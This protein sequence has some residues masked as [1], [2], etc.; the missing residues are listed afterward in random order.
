MKLKGLY[1][2]WVIVFVS[3]L[4]QALNSTAELTPG[5]FLKALTTHFECGRGDISV[6]FS[7]Y[8]LFMAPLSILSGKLSDK[9]GPRIVVTFNALLVG[10]GYVLMSRINFLWQMYLVWVVTGIG[11]SGYWVP[12]VSTVARWFTKRRGVAMGVTLTG[13]AVGGIIMPLFAQWLISSYG[14][15]QAY[16]TLG[17]VT[18]IILLPSVQLM[19]RS[20]QI[21]LK[22]LGEV[23]KDPQSIENFTFIELIK[24]KQFWLLGITL[25]LF[26]FCCL[27]GYVHTAPYAI[28]TGISAM[29]AATLLTIIAGGSLVGRLLIGSISDMIGG[30]LTLVCA[31]ILFTIGFILLTCSQQMWAFYAFAALFGIASGGVIT[32][33]AIVAADLFGSASLGM[34]TGSLLAVS[35]TIGTLGPT[36]AGYTFDVT[37]SY[38]LALLISITLCIISILLSL[39]LLRSSPA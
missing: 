28:D 27:L 10:L 30:R 38:N 2:G 36:F 14:W 8:F 17:L 12:T 7:L 4:V 19:K 15:R 6:T 20:Q 32:L 33:Q 31:L 5:V 24:N 21:G 29:V 18:L 26:Q 25:F 22:P 11:G 39:M 13:F 9:Y 1:Y 35:L 23:E 37:G 34:T 3:F 16:L